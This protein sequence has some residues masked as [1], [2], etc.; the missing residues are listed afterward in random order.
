MLRS[1]AA[2]LA[3]RLLREFD[4]ADVKFAWS[5]GKRILGQAVWQRWAGQSVVRTLKLSRYLVDRNGFDAVNDVIRH[6]IAHFK[7]GKEANHGPLWK[8]WAR[9]CGARPERCAS[10]SQVDM[11]EPKY[12]VVCTC[13]NS[14]V[15]RRH[16]RNLDLSSRLCKGCGIASEDKLVWRR[17]SAA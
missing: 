7:A 15:A 9:I 1:E 17:N 6:E 10:P 13:C 11:P 16:R 4:L 5:N 3:R 14:I 12:A 2:A 8:Q